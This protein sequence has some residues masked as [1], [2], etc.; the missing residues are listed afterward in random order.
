MRLRCRRW[1]GVSLRQTAVLHIFAC[2]LPTTHRLQS[3]GRGLLLLDL[4]ASHSTTCIRLDQHDCALLHFVLL[5]LLL[6]LPSR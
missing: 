6:D 3:R 4:G 2:L 1:L 5:P